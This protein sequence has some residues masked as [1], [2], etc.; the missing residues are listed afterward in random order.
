MNIDL[1]SLFLAPFFLLKLVLAN[2]WNLLCYLIFKTKCFKT[3]A[4]VYL[5]ILI[6]AFILLTTVWWQ[7]SPAFCLQQNKLQQRARG[8]D[9]AIVQMWN[10]PRCLALIQQVGVGRMG[11]IR[12]NE[13]LPYSQEVIEKYLKLKKLDSHQQKL[14][15][16]EPKLVQQQL[17]A[18]SL[19]LEHSPSHRDLL[20][21]KAL[22]KYRL[23]WDKDKFEDNIKQARKIDPNW[24][25]WQ[26]F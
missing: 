14:L 9:S 3:L 16:V 18:T 25:G 15:T 10:N 5:L 12:S 4:I 21:N 22:L 13:R 24:H 26:Q 23:T 20:I 19:A 11:E 7:P 17:E 1:L 8:W 6:Q 2:L